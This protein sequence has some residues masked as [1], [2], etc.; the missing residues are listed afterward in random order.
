MKLEHTTH[1]QPLTPAI[2]GIQV[3]ESYGMG[4]RVERDGQLIGLEPTYHAAVCRAN[5]LI[6][7]RMQ[8][9]RRDS[10][11]ATYRAIIAGIRRARA[12]C[13]DAWIRQHYTQQRRQ[14]YGQ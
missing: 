11:P 9:A 12:V 8:R 14:Q 6:A 13:A 4:Y 10:S 2:R 5:Y 1:R 7:D 3:L